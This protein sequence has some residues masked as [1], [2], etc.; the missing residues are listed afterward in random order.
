MRNYRKEHFISKTYLKHFSI[1][2]DGKGL[3]VI[4][5][6]HKYNKGIQKKNSGDNVFWEENYSDT[7]FFKDRK[8]IE[9]MFGMEIEPKYNGIIKTIEKEK[10]NIPFKI[11]E[12]IMQWIFYTKMRSPIWE[13]FTDENK[14]KMVTKN[15]Y[16][17]QLHLENFT[18]E[19][20]FNGA[21]IK[22]VEDAVNK[23]WT[24]YKNP[25]GK[26]WWTSDNPGYCIDLKKF[27]YD[28]SLIPDQFCNLNGVDAVLFYP[29][30]KKYCL[31]IHP[32]D[33]GE[34]VTLNAKNTPISFKT[35][36][37]SWYNSINSFTLITKKRLIIST[38]IESL[39]IVK[40]TK[41]EPNRK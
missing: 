30:T 5:F 1:N 39:K 21:L 26:Y 12:N 10:P 17:Q 15:R 18:D 19:N 24:V 23:R 9:K 28:K 34:D 27:E 25:Q 4:D 13:V 29:L 22:F 33:K 35:A 31:N 3:Y 11:K 40:Q 36:E 41:T 6:E 16:S 20:R 38:D 37:L 7:S 2:S 14:S 32:Y 8:A